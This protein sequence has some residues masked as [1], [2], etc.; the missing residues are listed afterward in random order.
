MNEEPIILIGPVFAGKST[1]GKLLAEKLGW[2]FVSL[3]GLE[4]GYIRS[5]GYDEAVVAAIREAEGPFAGYSYRRQFFDTAVTQFLAEH[6]SGVLE[7]GGGHP[8]VPDPV[9][10][11]RI[12][13]A[14]AP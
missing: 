2:S 1:V 3:D 7:L 10:Q 11:E 8:I 12:N 5:A 14:L 9:K 6:H 4:R 13:Q